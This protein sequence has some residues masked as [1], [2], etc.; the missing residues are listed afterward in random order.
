MFIY[1]SV[2]GQE[3]QPSEYPKKQIIMEIIQYIYR[4]IYIY[5]ERDTIYIYIHLNFGSII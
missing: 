5:I 3:L 4:Y 2:I 1:L